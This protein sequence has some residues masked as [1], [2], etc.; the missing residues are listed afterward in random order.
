M[1]LT[2]GTRLGPYEIQTPLGA[3]GMGEVYRARDTK[4]GREVALKVL[5]PHFAGDP[6][7]LARFQR[8][9]QVLASLNH[10]NIASIHGLEDS[11]GTPAL[12][13]ELV[14]GPTLADRIAA[15]RVP[16]EEAIRIARQIADAL[17]A[18]HD[19]GV[20]HRDLK[21][22]N[23]KLTPS[24]A[25][26]VLDFGLAKLAG[27]A[28]A[29]H[30]APGSSDRSVR[31]EAD[32]TASPTMTSPAMMTGV[33]FI[34]GTAGYMAPE[35]ARGQVVDKRA[36]IFAF[37]CVLYEMLTG[38]RL[39]DGRDVT[40]T[41]A[42]VLK[43]EPAWAALPPDTPPAL[44]RLL[45][46]TLE[47]DPDE[48]LRDIGDARLELT[49]ALSAPE[50][51]AVRERGASRR[52]GVAIL[53]SACVAV[54]MIST[55][56]AWWVMRPAPRAVRQLAITF[57]ATKPLGTTND[58]N[59]ALSP[60]GSRLVYVSGAQGSQTSLM[61]RALDRLD[62]VPV[63]GTERAHSPFFSPDGQWIG[64]FSDTDRTLK[65]VSIA[66]GPA[67][68]IATTDGAHFGAS[69]GTDDM[70][71]FA[72]PGLSRVPA[73]GG[74]PVAV[75]TPDAKQGETRHTFP[76]VLPEGR[77]VLFANTI[78]GQ[79]RIELLRFDTGERVVLADRGS[80][81]RY[82][83]TGHV[84]YSD[85]GRLFAV[86]FDLS[87][88]RAT[89]SPVPVLEGVAVTSDG[90]AV[91]SVARDGTLVYLPGDVSGGS[92]RRLVWVDQQG[93]EEAIAAAPRWYW[94]ARVSPD[95]TR[96]AL[97]VD[98]QGNSDIWIH[99]LAR[100]VQTRL[101]F[102]PEP[103]MHPVWSPDG[104]RVLFSSGSDLLV[105]AADGTGEAE[106]VATGLVS[107]IPYAWSRDGKTLLLQSDTPSA[108]I[109]SLEIGSAASPQ[110]VVRGPFFEAR[111]AL[112]PDGRW[113]AYQ[114]GESAR[115]EVYVRP[116]P[117]VDRGRWQVSTEGGDSP[118][119]S[120]DGRRIVYRRGGQSEAF[121]SVSVEAGPA[122]AL[123]PGTPRMLLEGQFLAAG[124][125]TW[126]M[127]PDGRL[128]MIKSNTQAGAAEPA[129]IV[130]SWF[131]ELKRLVP[132]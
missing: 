60:D 131:E 78:K 45:R 6:E 103:D 76:D 101:T 68:T 2:P 19:H 59:L 66:G 123:T 79:S 87:A 94:W 9:A 81:A 46:R 116:F 33:G 23:I 58:P 50:A 1:A 120:Q 15:G 104:R 86:P 40:E 22:A 70:I 38:A 108:D 17:A 36:D 84:V 69:W 51:V 95:G 21:P 24:G 63:P 89:G 29:G 34:L 126:D 18:A 98:D 53:V 10:P 28:D 43:T 64:Y 102:G 16:I 67:V 20:I 119:W 14:E 122:Q 5:P 82:V 97:E 128:L 93:A 114:S 115:A 92:Q 99:D 91:F 39:F 56:A 85:G 129:V 31:L 72:G 12:V 57:E 61:L 62:A 88:L 27:P 96:L 77:A 121:F 110:A 132:R 83:P 113:I 125:R 90:P 111:P 32:L 105:K 7:R 25:V 75:T 127:A 65:K 130:Q 48:R 49:E 71:T 44:R 37:G 74:T 73:G 106:R 109:Y 42:S 54:A 100:N 4:L 13:L 35:Q 26:K 52:H 30:Y 3:G 55:A 124:Q 80:S 41:L 47:K 11:D 8:E 117:D 107:T 118:V 112:S